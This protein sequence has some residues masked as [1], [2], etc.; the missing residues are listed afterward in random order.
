MLNGSVRVQAVN[1]DG[2]TFVDDVTAGDVWFFPPGVPHSIQA[3]EDG[4][5][6][7]LVFND[8]EFSEDETFLLSELIERNPESVI[9]KNFR[10]STETFKKIPE[11][12]LWIFNG[13][14]APKDIQKQNVTGPAGALPREKSYTY[15]FSEQA[16]YEVEGGSVKILDPVTC[17]YFVTSLLFP[18][19]FLVT[20]QLRSTTHLQPS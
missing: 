8:G 5:E 15:H 12:Q 19:H 14:P 7:L 10:T 3:F 4:C 1:D 6:F 13:T 9:A 17:T 2:Q 20:Q 11:G 16:P 18:F